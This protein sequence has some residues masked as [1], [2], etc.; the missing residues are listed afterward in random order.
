[1]LIKLVLSIFERPILAVITRRCYLSHFHIPVHGVSNFF[2]LLFLLPDKPC[3][4]PGDTEFGSF[5]L[6]SGSEFVFGARVEY[7]CNEG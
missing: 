5:E 2:L 7:R 3:G 6:T 4:H 1:M